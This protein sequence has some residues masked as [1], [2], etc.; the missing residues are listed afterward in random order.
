MNKPVGK[1]KKVSSFLGLPHAPR[2]P[3]FFFGFET[4]EQWFLDKIRSGKLIHEGD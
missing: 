2:T 1:R 4:M 3:T